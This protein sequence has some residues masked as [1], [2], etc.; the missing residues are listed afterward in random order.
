MVLCI[1]AAVYIFLT[2]ILVIEYEKFV[3]Y[4]PSNVAQRV[5]GYTV[6]TAQGFFKPHVSYHGNKYTYVLLVNSTY[7]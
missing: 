5:Q 3:L 1:S 2:I 7:L 6:V 4:I